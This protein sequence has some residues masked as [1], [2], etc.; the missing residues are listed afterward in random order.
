M[1]SS[2]L[3]QPVHVRSRELHAGR[4]L[5]VRVPLAGEDI[6]LDVLNV[7]QF[8][9]NMFGDTT[10]LRQKRQRLLHQVEAAVRECPQRNLCLCAGDYNTQ[11]THIAGL[12]GMST[13]LQAEQ[14]QVAQDSDTLRDLLIANQLVAV[15][16]W[17]GK[18]R[19]AFTYAGLQSRTQ[20]DYI[21]VRRPQATCCMRRCR[22]MSGFPVAA[23]RTCGMHRPLTMF[24]DYQWR[25][26][27]RPSESNYRVNV[28]QIRQ[29]MD[30][31]VNTFTHYK[32]ALDTALAGVNT[33]NMELINQ[34]ILAVSHR[35]YPVQSTSH[36]PYHEHT[37]VQSVVK[38]KWSYLA[39]MRKYTGTTLKQVISFWH[40]LVKFRASKKAADKASRAARRAKYEQLLQEAE[41]YAARQNQHQLFRVIRRLAPKQKYKKVQIYAAD[42]RV[43]SRAAE[44]L[45][46]RDHFAAI[47]QGPGPRLPEGQ[48][49]TPAPFTY[50]EIQTALGQIPAT[51][52]TPPHYAPGICWKAAAGSL[53]G[54]LHKHLPKLLHVT[55]PK[56]PQPWKDG[57]LALLG[58]PAKCGRRPG[59]FRPIC[60]QDPTGK[61]MIQ[62]LTNRLRPV[63]EAYATT[64]AQYA[65]LP[66]RSTEGALL[67][68]FEQCRGIR[69]NCQEAMQ[70]IQNK[71]FR[72]CQGTHVGGLVL[73]LDMSNAFDI[74][75]R[76]R[77]LGHGMVVWIPVPFSAWPTV[78]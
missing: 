7:Y 27:S 23:W 40:C 67:R 15:N 61:A 46:I 63:V 13:T 55:P 3:C 72:T 52:A 57:W 48:V 76:A 19:Q 36:M 32:Q 1:I 25:P 58:K 21:L 22:P 5:H 71:R 50:L 70:N 42:G 56:V 14:T 16:T 11:L 59:D 44:A 30:N 78:T 75:P 41:Y 39:A 33:L 62:I 37:A 47:F 8:V 28:E 10:E 6:A 53:A 77:C 29:D 51:K 54:I 20:I 60:L 26:P 35:Y 74:V 31:A 4:L 12:V 66:C 9:W 49:A 69:T 68:I 73:S 38:Q 34:V 64:S 17:T 2:S 24:V 45:E 18:R 65:Y 43:L